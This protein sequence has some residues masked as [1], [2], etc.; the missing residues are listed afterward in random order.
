MTIR[1]KMHY[2]LEFG[3]ADFPYEWDNLKNVK[4]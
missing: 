1:A 4:N 3:I 2:S